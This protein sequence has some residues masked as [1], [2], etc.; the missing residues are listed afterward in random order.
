MDAFDDLLTRDGVRAGEPATAADIAAV[1]ARFGPLPDELRSI[2]RA[3]NGV[4][5]GPLGARLLGP[6]EVLTA[7]GD[8]PDLV[9]RGLLPIVDDHESNHIALHL[10]PP[11]AHRLSH[12]PH[13]DGSRVL[14][15]DLASMLHALLEALD[16]GD[17]L[18]VVL[19]E[20]DGDYPPDS[21]R[22]AGD[23]ECACALMS[24]A[25]EHR[26][27]NDAVRLLDASNLDELARLLETD[28]FVRRDVIERLRKMT[29]PAVAELLRRDQAAFAAFATLA[30][31]A[32]SKAGLK[33]GACEGTALPVNGIW[34][35]LEAFFHRRA[36]PD[37]VPRMVAWFQDLVARRN[38]HKR[39]GHFM[40]D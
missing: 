11:L 6:A 38:P 17:T 23:Q 21:P 39:P 16:R 10:R 3:A 2:W 22:T 19:H 31:T 29:S 9:A 40:A 4:E 13:D 1:E 35:D 30:A 33:V 20:T 28:H 26:E 27:W 14:Y 7:F 25:G 12:L 34:I 32:A 36:I 15:R 24:T 5:L 37:A 18:D 8:A